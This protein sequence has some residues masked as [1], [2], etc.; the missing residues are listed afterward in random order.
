[1][2]STRVEV[3]NKTGL[4]P[5]LKIAGTSVP[6]H[7]A[8]D[9]SV[10]YFDVDDALLGGGGG[11]AT[12]TTA[13][14]ITGDGSGGSPVDL[15]LA[16]NPG[17]EDSSGLRIKIDPAGIAS[18]TASGLLV[19]ASTGNND[20]RWT[21]LASTGAAT[22]QDDDFRDA[23]IDGKWARVDNAGHS[24][25]VTWAEGGDSLSALFGITADAAG[26]V[27]AYMQAHALAVGDS[28]SCHLSMLGAGAVFPMAGLIIADGVTY[29]AGLQVVFDMDNFYGAEP[30]MGIEEWSNYSSRDVTQSFAMRGVQPMHMKLFRDAADV[31]RGY[32]SHDG[33]QWVLMGSTTLA[34]TPSHVGIFV[35]SWTSA[36]RQNAAFDYFRRQTG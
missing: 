26:E 31:Y 36:A 1:M 18:R 10:W 6:I 7:A 33:V 11:P 13:S 24:G 16:A 5:T 28:I 8:G 3:T 35:T 20:V 30:G 22:A 14:P 32:I 12:V 17:L 2:T 25:Y 15:A 19:P 27:H 21:R 34:L 23:A 29:G 4:P 9:S